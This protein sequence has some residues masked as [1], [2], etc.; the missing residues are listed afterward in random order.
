MTIRTRTSERTSSRRSIAGSP[1]ST[2]RIGPPT[3][4]VPL[5]PEP[6]CVWGDV[7]TLEADETAIGWSKP[8]TQHGGSH[9]CRVFT[10]LPAVVREGGRYDEGESVPFTRRFAGRPVAVPTSVTVQTTRSV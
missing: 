4:T 3:P 5:V 10:A 8:T 9:A 2:V 1:A 6:P 7:K